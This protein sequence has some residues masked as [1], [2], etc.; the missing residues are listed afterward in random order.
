MQYS[1]HVI[2]ACAG[3]I[4]ASVLQG[5]MWRMAELRLALAELFPLIAAD[6]LGALVGVLALNAMLYLMGAPV[7]MVTML[8]D[9]GLTADPRAVAV[10]YLA[11]LL[12]VLAV[13]VAYYG[14]KAYRTRRGP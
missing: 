5:P 11:G 10:G 1:F 14:W 12:A 7:G 9:L 8:A 3:G 13:G 6:T 4:V 2:K